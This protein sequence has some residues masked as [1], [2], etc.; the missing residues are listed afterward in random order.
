[1]LE[2]VWYD[3][4]LDGDFSLRDDEL[5]LAYWTQYTD[6][7]YT[8]RDF[9]CENSGTETVSEVFYNMGNDSYLHNNCLE[10][11]DYLVIPASTSG[12]NTQNV[13]GDLEL[14]TTRTSALATPFSAGLYE[15]QKISV[16]DY[17]ASTNITED[18]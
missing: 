16:E 8:S 12:I 3:I 6:T 5:G 9:S 2:R 4:D 7:I 14:G 17:T 10:K 1:M 15:I 11:G 18:R 13:T